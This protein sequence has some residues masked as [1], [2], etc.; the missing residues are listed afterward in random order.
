MSNWWRSRHIKIGKKPGKITGIHSTPSCDF[1]GT[2]YTV[3][4]GRIYERTDK[5]TYSPIKNVAKAR[6]ALIEG[7]WEGSLTVRQEKKKE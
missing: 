1:K 6:R 2:H 3:L 4:D 5:G 7:N